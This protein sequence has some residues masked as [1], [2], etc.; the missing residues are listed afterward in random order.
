MLYIYPSSHLIR[1]VAE[2][3]ILP[4]QVHL[5]HG[6]PAA[7]VGLLGDASAGHSATCEARCLAVIVVRAAAL[8]G[9]ASGALIDHLGVMAGG[10]GPT[11][12]HFGGWGTRGETQPAGT[13]TRFTFLQAGVHLIR[14]LF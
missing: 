14:A 6:D 10:R 13:D 4:V 2:L 1:L 7:G 3:D 5:L 8:G 12:C 9:G 11:S